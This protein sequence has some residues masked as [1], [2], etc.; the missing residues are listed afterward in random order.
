M[1]IQNGSKVTIKYS[2]KVDGAVVDSSEGDDPLTYEQGEG[3]II[4]GLE[5]K[6]VGLNAGEKK[7]VTIVPE[8]G[9]GERDPDAVKK[10]LCEEFQDVSALKVGS[11]VRGAVGGQEFQAIVTEIGDAE[12]TLD[13]NHPLA[14]KTLEFEIEVVNVEG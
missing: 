11:I 14:G 2:L 12:I 1:A 6:L 4:R 5:E 7:A 8:D 13:M 9:Y 10:V 3:Q